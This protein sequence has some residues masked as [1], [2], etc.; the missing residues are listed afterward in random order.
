M[1]EQLKKIPFDLR[2]K[3]LIYNCRKRG[4]VE[5]EL[6]L[7]NYLKEHDVSENEI[8]DME[9]L[10]MKPDWTLYRELTGTGGVGLM[11]KLQKYTHQRRPLRMPELELSKYSKP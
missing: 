2:L 8:D 11:E 6:I 3:R 1:I 7:S 4:I 9:K 10:L 5:N